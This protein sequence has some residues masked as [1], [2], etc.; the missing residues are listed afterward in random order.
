[1]S[2]I[3]DSVAFFDPI[4][5]RPIRRA[6][7]AACAALALGCASAGDGGPGEDSDDIASPVSYA[8]TSI[9]GIH[10]YPDPNAPPPGWL[11]GGSRKIWVTELAASGDSYDW[12]HYQSHCYDN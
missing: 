1:M 12:F 4:A 11:G 9:F 6:V 10:F 7:L 2:T 3:F 5:F 8:S